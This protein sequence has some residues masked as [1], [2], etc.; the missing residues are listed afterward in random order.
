MTSIEDPAVAYEKS[1]K[2]HEI[3]RRIRLPRT[4]AEYLLFKP[5]DGIKYEWT[6]GKLHKSKNMI[7]PEQFHI[8]ENLQRAFAK[9]NAFQNGDYFMPETKSRTLKES[10]RIPD[11]GYFT[12]AQKSIMRNGVATTPLFAVEIISNTDDAIEVDNK[13]E[14]Y[15]KAG[16]KLVWHIYP[17]AEKVL[18]FNSPDAI[19]VCRGK[20]PCSAESIIAGF[21]VS[22]EDIFK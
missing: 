11:I 8:I 14:E 2:L 7:N 3:K 17:K 21:N 22:A 20:T 15:F 10:Y 16:V 9:T 18:V 4:A 13:M 19:T 12:A 5:K 6:D 1:P